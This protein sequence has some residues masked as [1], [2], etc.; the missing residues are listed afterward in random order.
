MCSKNVAHHCVESFVF[1]ERSFSVHHVQRL[2]E[3]YDVCGVS[4]VGASLDDL[5][6]QL[7]AALC[8]HGGVE[9]GY[10]AFDCLFYEVCALLL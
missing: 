4:V 3:I 6:T 1:G 8:G 10:N 7:D 2:C 9:D 5:R